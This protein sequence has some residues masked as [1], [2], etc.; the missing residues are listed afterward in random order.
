[1]EREVTLSS[2]GKE[3]PLNDFARAIVANT[4]A[5]MVGTLK[6]SEADGEIVVRI[7]PLKK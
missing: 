2:A 7:G 1:M 6:K 5:A 3:V 4:I